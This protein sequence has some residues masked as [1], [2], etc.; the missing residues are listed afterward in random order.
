MNFNETELYCVP[1]A[2]KGER[3]SV[4]SLAIWKNGLPFKKIDFSANGKPI[5]KIA[6]LMVELQL[7]QVILKKS[8]VMKC[9]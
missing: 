3:M 4:Y 6:E 8:T 5:I 7:P 1:S 2:V 9:P